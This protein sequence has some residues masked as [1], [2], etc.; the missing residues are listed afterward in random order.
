MGAWFKE[1]FSRVL[2]LWHQWERW[3]MPAALLL[4]FIFDYFTLNRPD[5]LIDNSILLAYLI[6][7]AFVILLLNL[8]QSRA[9][10]KA[11]VY[12]PFLLLL[13]LQFAFGNLTSGLLVLYARSGT[14]GGSLF[15]LAFFAALLVGN[16]FIK[17]R[18]SQLRFHAAIFYLLFLAYMV[19]TVPVLLG[20]IGLG[21]FLL[22]GAAS[23]AVMLGFIVLLATVS[24]DPSVW[25]S[26]GGA[27]GVV[28]ILFNIFYFLNVI[29]P[30]PLALRDIGVYHSISPELPTGYKATYENR[31]W[32]RFWESTSRT[33]HITAGKQAYCFSA[34]FAPARLS[35]PIY[36]RWEHYD[37]Q[38]EKWETTTRI[39]FQISG[40]REQGYRAYSLTSSLVPGRWRCTVETSN[41]S[42]IGRF[43]LTAIPA[44]TSPELSQKTL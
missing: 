35:A 20:A 8:K 40:G 41:G 11:E 42:I 1:Q 10:R 14:I 7:S 34:V 28:F 26:A 23:I 38:K 27:M 16:E 6:L 22:S 12:Q 17:N 30:V 25:R 44:D 36:H 29:P 39:S 21:V 19:L 4:G 3:T 37:E 32:Y 24:K 43:T 9:R 2:T 13:I 31:P 5:N 18:Y 15:F 33:Y